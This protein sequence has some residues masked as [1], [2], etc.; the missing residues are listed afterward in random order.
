M[1][2]LNES[3]LEGEISKRI[4][5]GMPVNSTDILLNSTAPSPTLLPLP[6]PQPLTLMNLLAWNELRATG[7]VGME[8]YP[9]LLLI[10][11]IMKLATS[12]AVLATSK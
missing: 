11:I 2:K 5:L 8:P 4:R 12:V 3:T 10:P 7:L 6:L 9:F 1:E